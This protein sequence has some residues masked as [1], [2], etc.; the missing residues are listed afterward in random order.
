MLF[1]VVDELFVCVFDE[2]TI[3][4]AEVTIDISIIATYDERNYQINV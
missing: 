4:T 2:S 1:L 3:P